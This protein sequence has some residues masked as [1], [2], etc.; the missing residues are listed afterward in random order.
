MSTEIQQLNE[1]ERKISIEMPQEETQKYFEE[2]LK[3]EAKK[4]QIPGFRKGKA[5]LSLVKKMYG[6]ALF[7]DNLD[8]IAENK[9]WDEIDSQGIE[10]LGIPKLTDLDLTKDGG[11]KFEIQFEVTP[12]I[13]I[14][15]FEDIEVEKA[16]F[17]ISDK[18]I[19]NYIEYI[20][21][22]LRNEEPAEKIDSMDYIVLLE[23]LD[24]SKNA[25]SQPKQFSIYLKNPD[26][27]QEFINL[28]IGK[29]LNEE[30]ETSI[31]LL[32]KEDEKSATEKEVIRYKI[33]EIKK[34]ILPEINDELAKK[35]SEGK[36]ETLEDLKKRLIEEELA[37]QNEE[38]KLN[39]RKA[40]RNAF[41]EKYNFTPPPSL[42]L[43]HQNQIE[44]EL[45]TKYKTKVIPDYLQKD[46]K[47]IAEMDVK[48]YLITKSIMDKY[49]LH[50]TSEEV[51]NYAQELADKYNQDKD[52]ILKYL[53][54]NKS[55][56]L[57]EK[58]TDKLFDFLLSKIKIKTKK[59]TI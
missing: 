57:S 56:L 41:I 18:F 17:E 14:E 3:K 43:R 25:E 54:S 55:T 16:E 51:E 8:K 26:V 53:Y 35:Y 30:L 44:E 50:L 10:V 12:K 29:N 6:E 2:I 31:P 15:N 5:P 9:F 34:V 13:E 48:W 32:N 59:V 28:L 39:L 33:L 7:Y 20:R 58:E 45:K 46:I 19:E 38:E 22:Q 27:N 11:I 1:S 21:F 47:E 23:K 36:I 52:S 24:D 37:Y 4:I 42:I 49:N 40:I